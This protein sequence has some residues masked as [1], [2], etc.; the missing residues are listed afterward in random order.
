ME[1]HV[2]NYPVLEI[3][4][5]LQGEGF[6]MGK[7]ATFIRLAGCNLRCSWCDTQAALDI[8]QAV[9][10]N[11][12]EIVFAYKIPHHHVVITGGEPTMYNLKPLV[13]ELHKLGKYVAI[14]TN[15]TNPVPPEWGID[16]ITVS[17]KPQSNYTLQCKANELKYIVDDNFD[18]AC[19]ATNAVDEGLTFLQV[20]SG[21]PESLQKAFNLIN[22]FPEKRL[23]LG[24]QLHKI[25]GL[26]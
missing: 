23:R 8:A 5:S 11:A 9:E 3:F 26:R 21:R 25:L 22:Q 7:G 1:D 2:V 16:W 6:H 10:M 18:I 19:I 4:T 15:G 12:K 20:E 17:P 24:V 14:E 13:R